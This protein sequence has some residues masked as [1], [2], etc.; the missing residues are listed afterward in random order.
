MIKPARTCPFCGHRIMKIKGI[1]G[2]EFYKCLNKKECGAVI[3]FDCDKAY[4]DRSFNS[5]VLFDRRSS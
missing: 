3:S 2:I 1:E 4:K 5:D